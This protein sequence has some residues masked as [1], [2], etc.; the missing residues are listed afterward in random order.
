[1]SLSNS[2]IPLS[3]MMVTKVIKHQQI[4]M[5]QQHIICLYRGERSSL[6]KTPDLFLEKADLPET[7]NTSE[8]LIYYY[9]LRDKNIPI[10]LDYY[11]SRELNWFDC[12]A[13]LIYQKFFPSSNQLKELID[14]NPYLTEDHNW[15]I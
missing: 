3:K 4:I 5:L 14:D 11:S 8:L 10:S 15:F 12:L 2:D 7:T 6:P 13:L 9:F 1:M